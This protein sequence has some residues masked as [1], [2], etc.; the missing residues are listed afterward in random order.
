MKKLFFLVAFLVVN[1]FF[2]SCCPE[3]SLEEQMMEVQT[4]D[5]CG[6]VGQLPDDP[7]E[8]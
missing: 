1:S 6:E 4:T 5:C 2:T 3:I 7:E 8:D